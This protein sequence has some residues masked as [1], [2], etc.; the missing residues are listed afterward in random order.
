MICPGYDTL[1]LILTDRVTSGV[2]IT[3][4]DGNQQGLSNIDGNLQDEEEMS[5]SVEGT[6]SDESA[7]LAVG[8]PR[9]IKRHLEEIIA[10]GRANDKD[11][12]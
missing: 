6:Q 4:S 12:G 5:P 2:N 1:K 11:D 10:Q 8:K 3:S 7:L 9:G